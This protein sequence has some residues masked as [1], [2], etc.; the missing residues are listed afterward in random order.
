M[1]NSNSKFKINIYEALS[2]MLGAILFLS[3]GVNVFL[4]SRMN[5]EKGR[6][7]VL[8]S[9]TKT[10]SAQE[11]YSLFECPCCCKSIGEC[12]CPMAQERKN[13]VDVLLEVGDFQSEDEIAL[14]YVKKYGLNSFLDK[15]KQQEI[16]E[17]L[18]KEAPADR[19]IISIS[20]DS[21]DFGD[22]SQKEGRA[23][24]SFDLKNEGKSDLVIDR[25]ETSCG[26]TFASI[27]F[28]GKENP[29]FTMPGHDNPTDWEGVTIPP[30]ANAQLKVM[31]DPTV[32]MDF[33]GTAIRGISI[34]S[35]DPIDFEKEVKVELNQ[36]D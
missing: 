31:Y 21:Y 24:T 17:K 16:K 4:I 5:L 30:G 28:E 26:C 36:V 23:F 20:P 27:I 13:Y 8:S 2:W 34:F 32:H 1:E 3:L 18:I 7:E 35:N 15:D 11:I 12:T 10:T 14:A 22:V 9:S 25:L 29:Y 33:R 19:P 6:A